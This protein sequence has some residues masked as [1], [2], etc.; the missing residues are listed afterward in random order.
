MTEPGRYQGK[1]LSA[2]EVTRL[3]VAGERDF[4]GAVLR[5]CNFRGVDLSGADFSG[6]DIRSA[7]FVEATL[8][9]TNFSHARAGLQRWWIVGQFLLIVLIAALAGFLQGYAGVLIGAQLAFGNR[10][11]ESLISGIT[12]LVVTVIVFL[13]IACQGFTL[14]AMGIIAVAVAV[15]VAI[16]V[17]VTFDVAITFDFAVN[18]VANLVANLVVTIV[19]A[20]A[21][22]VTGAFAFPF[23][24][25]GAVTVAFAFA[26]AVTVAFASAF[27]FPFAFPDVFVCAF[28]FAFAS[29]LFSM[30]VY[31]RV[32]REDPKFENLRIIGLAFAAL[33]GTTFSGADLTGATFVHATL[34]S[35]NFAAS[36]QR[37]TTLT[38]VRWYQAQQ[39]DRAR[40]GTANLQDHRVRHLLNTLNG[41]DQDLSNTN[42]RGA[43][44]AGAKLRRANLSGANL[45]GAMLHHAELHGA[46][47]TE[48][49][50]IGTDF[51]AAQLTG[52]CLEAWNYD[53]TT[54]FQ[55]I[56]CQYVFLKAQPNALGWRERLPHNPDKCFAPGDFEKYFREVLDEVR[57]L[58]RGGVDPQAFKTAFQA[59]MENHGIAPRDVRSISR[60]DGDVLID[61]AIP[62]SVAKPDV[63]RTFDSAYE[64][65]LPAATAQALLE[66]ERRSKQ[67]L[68][69]LANK[70]IDSISSVL[71]NLTIN[72]TAMNHSQN[73][74]VSTGDGSF[75]AGG[76]VN[77]SGSILNLGQISG[78]VTNQINQIPAPA[79]PDQPNLRDLLTQLQTAVETDGEL[80]DDE[81]AEALQAVARIAT[82]GTEPNPDDKTKGIVK[83]ATAT[84]K[85]MTET[86]T[87]ASKLADACTKLLPLVLSLFTLV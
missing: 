74:N 37:P 26:G 33:D 16:A 54:I 45:G 5:G 55:D 15:I 73:P 57:L 53:D 23:A 68:I 35:T 86:L 24:F 14:R 52:A 69:Q 46:T 31:R 58:I 8:R 20:L 60:R 39:L 62:A 42:L 63:A 59:L 51:T 21:S 49:N 41:I 19:G 71:S 38:H 13:V 4:R 76:D 27:A 64:I 48:A 82:A 1:R 84:L 32:H 9:G 70:S 87:D 44:L 3:Y 65:A 29:L 47:L 2:T 56:D 78:Q 85:G 43:N 36:R 72:T 30:Y 61:V 75:Y 11:T 67:D 7:R 79:T 50:C 40:L 10:D 12:D 34:K 66:A 25:A 80:S 17:A 22:A 18:L 83:R 77:L 6:A 81:K 28:A